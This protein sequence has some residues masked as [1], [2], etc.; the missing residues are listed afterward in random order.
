M[1]ATM[2]NW[3]SKFLQMF[4]Y[5]LL[6]A[7]LYQRGS[8]ES[9]KL[10]E[11]EP[12]DRDPR[13]ADRTADTPWPVRRGGWVLTLYENSLSIGLFLLFALSFAWHAVAGT[14]AYRQQELAHGGTR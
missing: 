10:D 14:R 6:T 5:V 2:M 9:R 1:E 4:A 8:A 11:P 3:E 7:F 12:V 13:L